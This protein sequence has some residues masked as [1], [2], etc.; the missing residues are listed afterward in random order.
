M[1]YQ[2]RRGDL[3]SGKKGHKLIKIAGLTSVESLCRGLI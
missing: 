3:F 2:D 1:N